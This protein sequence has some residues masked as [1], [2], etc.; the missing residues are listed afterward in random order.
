[1]QL[2]LNGVW[3]T[4]AVLGNALC[5][6]TIDRLGRVLAL[7]LGWITSGIG[8]IG[9]C[10]SLAV[11]GN[12]GSRSAAITGVFF[13]YWHIFCYAFFVDATT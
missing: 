12:T 1:M 3:S 13:L 9:I 5:A 8:V 2:V 11:F 7:K 6:F 10:A 4:V